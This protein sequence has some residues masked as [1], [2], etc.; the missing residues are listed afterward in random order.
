MALIALYVF[1]AFIVIF[2]A[3]FIKDFI[4]NRKSHY[5]YHKGEEIM[6]FILLAPSV[7]LAFFLVLLPIITSLGFSFKT[8]FYYLL[9]QV[10]LYL[11]SP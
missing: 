11:P 10:N 3:I 5:K 6:A 8:T 7:V 1:A 9:K 4:K 2:L